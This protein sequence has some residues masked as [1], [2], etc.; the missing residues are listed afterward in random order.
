M[1]RESRKLR[2][3]KVPPV[4]VEL[5][6]EIQLPFFERSPPT[7]L[8]DFDLNTG[9]EPAKAPKMPSVDPSLHHPRGLVGP[10]TAIVT[11]HLASE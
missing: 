3:C 8:L 2:G 9:R 10:G 7:C 1:R 5:W 11:T 6:A 4:R